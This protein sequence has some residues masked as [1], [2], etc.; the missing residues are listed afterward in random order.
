VT[1]YRRIAKSTVTSAALAGFAGAVWGLALARVL[2]ESFP[3]S[4][5]FEL[6]P[7]LL[8]TLAAVVV[9]V[10]GW[11]LFG[12][13]KKDPY[14]GRRLD[15]YLIPLLL[16]VIYLFWPGVAPHVGWTLLG[17]SLALTALLIVEQCAILSLPKDATLSLSK[18]AILSLPKDAILPCFL[19]CT[20]LALYL[21][22]LGPT[23]GQADTF[24]FQVVAPTLGV[25]HPTGYPL[26]ILS[27]K[28]F[29]LLPFGSVAW[30]V[31]LT[32][33][34]FA[35]AAV[36]LLYQLVR[37]LTHRPLAAFIAALAFAF[38]RVFWGQAVVAEVYALHN[39][40]VAVVL[41]GLVAVASYKRQVT[42]YRRLIYLLAFL[43]GLSFTNHLTTA[44]L[45]PAVGLTFLF[46]RPRIGWR[47]W[48]VAT[49]LFLLGLSLYS[50][51]YSRWPMLHDGVWMSPGEFWRYTTG[52]QFGGA[53]RL[54]A[55]REDPTRYRIVGRLLCE[56][57]GRPGLALGAVGLAWLTI[58]RWRVALI[59]SVTFLA[60]VWYAL[61]YYVPDVSVF[62]LPAHLVLAAWLG[63]GM[64]AISDSDFRG[65]KRPRK[66]VV[67][68]SLSALLP[69]W[70]LWTNLPLV[71]Q[72]GER[73]AYVW[74]DRVL[75]LPLAPDAAILAGSV[76]IAPLYY[77]QRIEG[78]RP[79]LDIAVLA[80]EA[81]YRAELNARLAAGQTV[82]LARFLPG[83]EGLYHLRSLGPLTEVGTAAV[84][85]PPPLDRASSVRLAPP[86]VPPAA[87]G[88]S[89]ELLGLTGPVPGP[90]GGAGLTLYW[91]ADAPIAEVYHVRL[92]LVDVREPQ[93][94]DVREPPLAL[95]ARAGESN[96][97][98]GRV[99]WQG[100]DAG[101]HA[102]NN[103]YPTP[104]WRPGEVV[105]D[106]HEI[107]PLAPGPAMPPGGYTVQVG[108]FRPF[109]DEG[110]TTAN[111]E[112]WVSLV[113][114][115]PPVPAAPSV[116]A[117]LLRARFGDGPTLMG[118][119]LPDVIAAGTAVEL[120]LYWHAGNAVDRAHPAL[121]W[122]NSRNVGV[123]AQVLERRG[124]SR[125]LLQAPAS[126]GDYDLRLGLVK[127]DDRPLQARCGWL[128]RPTDDCAL[129]TVRVTEAA[130]S[131]LA[132]FEGKVLLLDAE[133][134]ASALRP[135]Q[136]VPLTLRWQGLQAM[137][138][139]Y[140]VSVQL[141]GPDGRLYGQT[142][143][144]PVQG[145]FPTGQWSP[146]Q[147][148]ADPYQVV[149]APDAPPGRYRV[150]VVVYLLATQT[151]LP[152]VDESGRATGDIAWVGELD[153]EER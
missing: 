4:P 69:L 146:G 119:D 111:G 3:A 75:D 84:T 74:G 10:G 109:S 29:S 30:R 97:S 39:L 85:E 9:V 73:E 92:R 102:A 55:W 130:A 28:L 31:N 27:G 86:S 23:V 148:I 94:N 6:L 89:V 60:Y 134:G 47:G 52:Q 96:D 140:T 54:D 151:R 32:S 58:K 36:V 127:P 113:Q 51:I 128:A 150:G 82:Y 126:P 139:N 83:L 123:E 95:S 15:F 35:T 61:C 22:T 90:D 53:L 63:V 33:A 68:L 50:Y 44:L 66:S 149:L 18:D 145:T 2:A 144:W 132:N 93:S 12:R 24:E 121:T 70:L 136:S 64:A 1:L 99:W 105:A 37:R 71:D 87:Q 115:V 34:V 152:L 125:L 103:Y 21:R 41:L 14:R 147:R 56:A 38:S 124:R 72:S 98:E 8:V 101:G 49:G 11:W 65:L 131:A 57:F 19:A 153:V 129:T 43:L 80:D 114:L 20:T 13:R 122:V 42:S 62:L 16:V 79:D 48:L 143:A 135:G 120:T 81:I 138:E 78:R 133:I 118:V 107:P 45:L 7:T 110:L 116:P 77:L 26:Y 141:I 117:H 104:A 100:T 142:D 46:V 88:G 137:E 76:R 112:T 106:Y 5:T 40:F 25:A 108:L 17:G 59:T 67:F 91:R